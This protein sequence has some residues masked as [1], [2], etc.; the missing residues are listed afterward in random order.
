MG[1]NINRAKMLR[2]FQLISNLLPM[3]FWGLVLFSFEELFLAVTTLFSALIHELGHIICITLT[4]ESSFSLRGVINGFRIK[5]KKIKSYGEETL[6]YLAGPFAN[7][8]VFLVCYVLSGNVSEKLIT[9]GTVNLVTAISNLMPIRGYDGYGALRA[10]IKKY[11]FPSQALRILSIFSS[12][13]IFCFSLFSLYLIDR[14]AEGYWIFAVFFVS[15]VKE[16]DMGLKECF[17]RFKEEL[18]DFTSFKELY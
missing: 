11:E 1:R 17:Q 12:A 9:I 6:I 7:L 18:R 3:L 15:M 10:L 5:A 4:G 14:Y 13:M 16:I 2:F 8:I